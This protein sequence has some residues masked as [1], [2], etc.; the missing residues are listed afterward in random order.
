MH[1]Y[2]DMY[3]VYH[4]F[5]YGCTC[6]CV[7]STCIFIC[8]VYSLIMHFCNVI[9]YAVYIIKRQTNI[10]IYIYKYIIIYTHVLHRITTISGRNLLLN[11]PQIL[12]TMVHF[13]VWIILGHLNLANLNVTPINK[14]WSTPGIFLLGSVL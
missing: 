2:T 14:N 13:K 10:Y 11:V 3:T 5:I 8:S 6:V 12:K 1:I 4:N 7:S 9:A